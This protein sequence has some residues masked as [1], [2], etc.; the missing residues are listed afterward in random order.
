MPR[1]VST[2]VVKSGLAVGEPLALQPGSPVWPSGVLGRGAGARSGQPRSAPRAH[3]SPTSRGDVHGHGHSPLG[4]ATVPA[5]P[6]ALPWGARLQ[7]PVCRIQV[8]ALDRGDRGHDG[9]P[10]AAP[11]GQDGLRRPLRPNP[12]S[13]HAQ[14]D[15]SPAGRPPWASRLGRYV[16]PRSFPSPAQLSIGLR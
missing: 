10:A 11:L 14:P 1:T 5:C 15:P 2:F 8:A 16:S 9:C 7:F 4:P 3:A 13:G 12:S 6:S